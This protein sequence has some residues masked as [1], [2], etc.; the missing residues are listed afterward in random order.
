MIL[1][2]NQPYF[3]PYAGFFYKA[4]LSDAIVILDAVQFPRGTTWMTRNR[5]K[6]DKG[7]LWMTVP[8]HKKGL[9]LQR[10]DEV[11]IFREGRWSKKHLSSLKRAYGKA[12]FF[13]DHID[14]LEEIFSNPFERLIDLNLA[15]IRYLMTY[16]KLETRI[17]LLSENNIQARGH[18][19][20]IELC[21]KYRASHFLAQNAARKYLYPSCFKQAG[22][23]IK[24]FR[25]A[26]HVYPQLW[27]NFLPNLSIFDLIFNCGPK[28]HDILVGQYA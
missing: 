7:T 12:P 24:F 1:S 20:L 14:F 27:G 3:A 21:R 23:E 6:D 25:P 2:A 9:G 10:I 26:A 18:H 8:V 4:H 16:L 19:R 22:I 17:L 28:S 11:R 5:F 13:S 15:V